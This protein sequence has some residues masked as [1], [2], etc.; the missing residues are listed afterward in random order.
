LLPSLLIDIITL[1]G[2]HE[3]MWKGDTEPGWL[4]LDKGKVYMAEVGEADDNNG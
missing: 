1:T 2:K 3:S 4:A